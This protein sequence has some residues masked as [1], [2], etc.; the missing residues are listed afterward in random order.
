MCAIKVKFCFIIVLTLFSCGGKKSNISTLRDNLCP[1]IT[2]AYSNAEWDKII[3]LTDSLIMIK[4]FNSPTLGSETNNKV[5]SIPR[6]LPRGHSF[7]NNESIEDMEIIYAEALGATNRSKEGIE[8]LKKR[9]AKNKEDYF[10]YQTIGVLFWIDKDFPNA[11][12]NFKISL[13]INPTYA[14]PYIYIAQIEESLGNTELAI[15]NYLEAIKL[16]YDNNFHEEVIE[17]SKHIIKHDSLNT[18]ARKFIAN[19]YLLEKKYDVSIAYLMKVFELALNKDDAREVYAT[20]MMLGDAH[21]KNDDF[22]N[23]IEIFEIA[24]RNPELL[25]DYCWFAYITLVK[26]YK[27]LNNQTKADYYLD[28]ARKTDETKTQEWLKEMNKN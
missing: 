10:A 7:A 23:S 4:W 17:Y 19:I 9:T 16:F 20:M 18:S 11:I 6:G 24:C 3:I 15:N 22:G 25:G 26:N 13:A 12:T 8:L 14:R 27:K 1:Q 21:W 5:H 28:L 2:D